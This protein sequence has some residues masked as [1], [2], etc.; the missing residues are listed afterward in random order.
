MKKIIIKDII[1]F[2]I[3]LILLIL[4][5]KIF[6]PKD[7]TDK[8]GMK[9]NGLTQIYGEKENTVDIIVLGNSESFTSIIPMKMW[10][11][12]GYTCQICG[13]P[14]LVLPDTMKSLYDATRNQK[15]KLVVLEANAIFD[16]VSITIPFSRLI[17]TLLPITEYHDRWKNLRLEDFYKDVE[18]TSTDYMKGFKYIH[19]SKPAD[20][21]N[22]M[23]YSEDEYYISIKGKAYLKILNEYC[24][25]IGAKFMVMSVPSTVN[26]SYEKHNTV[27]AIADK[28][29][30]A[31]LD[32]NILTKELGID[33]NIDTL[34]NGDHM[35][36][37]G[38]LKLTDYF[39]DYVEKMNILEDHRNDEKYDSWNKDLLEFKKEIE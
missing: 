10:E 4:L 28:E 18:Y 14:G 31:F 33:W 35:N 36:Y 9:V 16:E 12:C 7:N 13:Y 23:K 2:L 20:I 11:D 34:D 38:S 39:E 3:L 24:K 17:Q 6:V 15:P 8:A 21:E 30:F 29:Q 26:W 5:S 19:H 1:F 27:Q 37:F 32:F 25:K 22:Y